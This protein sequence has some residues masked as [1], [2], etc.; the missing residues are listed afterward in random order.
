MWAGW[1]VPL[2]PTHVLSWY[3]MITPC[4]ASAPGPRALGQTPRRSRQRCSQE[5]KPPPAFVCS[6]EAVLVQ[7]R[8][9]LALSQRA[10][11]YSHCRAAQGAAGAGFAVEKIQAMFTVLGAFGSVTTSHSSSST[12]FSMVLSLDFSATGRITAAH[13]QV[14]C[15]PHHQ[16]RW[17]GCG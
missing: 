2:L 8:H 1:H 3:G 12:R 7:Q 10:Q 15:R 17:E 9:G 5:E 4:P 13:L 14:R 16:V 11:G 6:P